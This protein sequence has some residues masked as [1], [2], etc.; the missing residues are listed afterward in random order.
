MAHGDNQQQK[1]P[2][3]QHA[4]RSHTIE[5]YET[6]QRIMKPVDLCM[7]IVNLL[8]ISRSRELKSQRQNTLSILHGTSALEFERD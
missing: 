7:I 3:L 2:P 4:S 8:L 5:V 1:H 6:T